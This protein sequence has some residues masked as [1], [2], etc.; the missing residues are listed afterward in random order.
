MTAGKL[1]RSARLHL[2]VPNE[3]A[4]QIT[5]SKCSRPIAL[6]DVIEYSEGRL[7]HLDCKRPQ[8]LTAEE[9]ALLYVYCS[10]HAAARCQSCALDY[11]LSELAGDPLGGRTNL[12]P[13]CRRDLT[14]TARGHLYGCASL[15]S[16]V[17]LRAQQVRE[18]A[19]RL[20]KRSQQARDR[21]DTLLR[22]AEAALFERQEAL[23]TAMRNR[24]Q[25]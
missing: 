15:P 10:T 16:E 21:S 8:T 9:R 25:N 24:A 11:R 17:R 3:G 20:V 23:R 4:V 18:A 12:C 5:C 1:E 14:E 6:M 7:A 13:R 22:E 2:P 19:Q